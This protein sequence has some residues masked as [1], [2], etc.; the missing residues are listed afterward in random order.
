M[1]NT[2]TQQ[3]RS[4]R[5]AGRFGKSERPPRSYARRSQAGRPAGPEG[6]FSRA[7]S[8]TRPPFQRRKQQP[9]G[10]QGLLGQATRLAPQLLRRSPRRQSGGQLAFLT[11]LG[12]G[13]GRGGKRR[14]A[15]ALAGVLGAGAAGTALMRRRRANRPASPSDTAPPAASEAAREE[16]PATS[17]APSPASEE[18][19]PTSEEPPPTSEEPP[20]T[21]GDAP[22]TFK[23]PP[24][25][26]G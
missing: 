15:K 19:P 2:T 11:R 9:T 21:S 22:P 3:R 7:R 13:A 14:N 23:Q 4:G 26:Q 16:P 17:E 20:P 24:R 6:R 1:S 5:S 8:A 18:P 10:I 25:K 12:R